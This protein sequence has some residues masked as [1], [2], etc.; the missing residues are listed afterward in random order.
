MT[1][2]GCED[3]D[4]GRAT[5]ARAS[6]VTETHLRGWRTD[7]AYPS[8][9]RAPPAGRR[10]RP[11]FPAGTTPRAVRCG[12][13]TAKPAEP[14]ADSS[15]PKRARGAFQGLVLP[16][17][18]AHTASRTT[19]ARSFVMVLAKGKLG[20]PK[21]P[22]GVVKFERPVRRALRRDLSPASFRHFRGLHRHLAARRRLI[23][24]PR[25]IRRNSSMMRSRPTCGRSALSSSASSASP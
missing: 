20:D 10:G 11:W 1:V 25:P 6:I 18:N 2:D 13:D 5:S 14:D 16:W 7:R 9:P 17:G 12:R 21:D 3:V 22:A 24:P 4:A 15:G 19:H 8:A 23:P